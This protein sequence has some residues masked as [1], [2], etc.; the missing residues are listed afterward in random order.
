[1]FEAVRR[2]APPDREDVAR[3]SD[4]CSQARDP[5][6]ASRKLAP[7]FPK[8]SKLLRH[9]DFQRV[10]KQGRRHFAAHM[11]VFYQ[12]RRNEDEDK[13][14][15]GAGPRVGFTAGRVLGGAVQRNRIKRRLREAVRHNL[16][17]LAIAVDVVINPKK[18]ALVAEFTVL[19]DEV[20]RA[21]QVICENQSRLK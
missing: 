6:P 15:V 17:S 10:Y 1:V 8:S 9:A 7:R 16:A 13:D 14:D 18:S 12:R 3:R 2:C 5:R 20:A 11:T 19:N 4:P 21:F